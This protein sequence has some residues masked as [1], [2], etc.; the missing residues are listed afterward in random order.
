MT[1]PPVLTRD[2]LLTVHAAELSLLEPAQGRVIGNR[3]FES[4]QYGELVQAVPTAAGLLL[5][6]ATGVVIALDAQ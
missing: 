4:G 2:G 6:S 3:S 1:G 5:V